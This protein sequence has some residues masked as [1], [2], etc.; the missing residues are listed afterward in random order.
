MKRLLLGL[1]CSWLPSMDGRSGRGAGRPAHAPSHPRQ[2]S[3]RG[4]WAPASAAFPIEGVPKGTV[5][6]SSG[7][8]PG[9]LPVPGPATSARPVID[10]S[11]VGPLPSARSSSTAGTHTGRPVRWDGVGEPPIPGRQRP[12]ATVQLVRCRR[13]AV[14][15]QSYGVPAR[16]PPGRPSR[17]QPVGCRRDLYEANSVDVNPQRRKLTLGYWLNPCWAVG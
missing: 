16:S 6:D 10:H 11:A 5:S 14:W 1:G 4:A 9:T 17:K 13:A 3:R 2:P 12:P 8:A 15:I 7:S